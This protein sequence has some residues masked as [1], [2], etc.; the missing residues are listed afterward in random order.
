MNTANNLNPVIVLIRA[1]SMSSD[2]RTIKM[3]QAV[4]AI[5]PT[6]AILWSRDTVKDTTPGAILY[7]GAA[8]LGSAKL[9]LYL[10]FWITFC[11]RELLKLR[12]QV[13][14][15]CD[16]EG[17]WPALI[18]R[19]F[20]PQV[21]IV[22]DIHDVTAGK[23]AGPAQ[24]IVHPIMLALDRFL[25]RKADVCFAPDPERFDQLHI[26]PAQLRRYGQ[27]CRV[28][29]NS[30]TLT[31]AH[32]AI[33]LKP[34]QKLTVSYV[35]NLTRDIRGIEF[36]L[37][38]IPVCPKVFFNVAGMGADLEYFRR[39]FEQLK[40]LNFKFWG[41]VDHHKAMELNK[42]ADVMISLLNPNYPNYRYASSTKLFEAFH[43]YKPII[44]SKRT[45]TAS[46]LEKAEWGMAIDYTAVALEQTLKAI[47]SKG[48]TF[49]LN[50]ARVEQFSWT[51]MEKRIRATYAALR[52]S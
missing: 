35:G 21:K 39:Q 51:E 4:S 27:K 28:V 7:H 32:R 8:P 2:T 15:G 18:Y 33:I 25:V 48:I 47:T 38:A 3:Y 44:V 41:R 6:R 30:E 36:I 34:H 52:K 26:S 29:Y 31:K 9:Y 43:L 45:T 23:Y 22:F 14:H 19:F 13:I 1:N 12:P 16:S 40:A 49:D 46:I 24:A 11:V 17:F 20:N 50:S 42:E 37:E 10:P 5:A